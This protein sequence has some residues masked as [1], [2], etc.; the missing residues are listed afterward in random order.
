MGYLGEVTVVYGI[1]D[2]AQHY[3]DL[4]DAMRILDETEEELWLDN[5]PLR[6]PA[7]SLLYNAHRYL[8]RQADKVMRGFC[9]DE[10]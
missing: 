10:E 7:Q 5:K 1:D 6:T 3:Q 2:T 9:K 8:E 4:L